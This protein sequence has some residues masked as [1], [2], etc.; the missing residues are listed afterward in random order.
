MSTRSPP[1]SSS[2]S[3]YGA[4]ISYQKPSKKSSFLS[5]RKEK[6]TTEPL[7]SPTPSDNSFGYASS[8][9]ATSY[10]LEQELPSRP[11]ISHPLDLKSHRT[12]SGSKS[13]GSSKDV[14]GQGSR[15]S[16]KGRQAKTAPFEDE[17]IEFPADPSE[18]I[19]WPVS[20]DAESLKEYRR[21]ATS[22][23]S[24]KHS[25]EQQA[26]LGRLK[27][28]YRDSGS[29]T[30]SQFEPLPQTPVDDYTFSQRPFSI[31]VVVAAPIAGVETMD[32]LVDGMNGS[33][34]DDNPYPSSGGHASRSQFKKMG[35]H[36]LYH[37]PLPKPP[38]G[39]TLGVPRKSKKQSESESEDDS[40]RASS[41]HSWKD[42]ERNSRPRPSRTPSNMTVTRYPTFNMPVVPSSSSRT[43]LASTVDA[44]SIPDSNDDLHSIRSRP[45]SVLRTSPP[46]CLP[47]TAPTIDEIIKTHAPQV[48]RAT[49]SRRTSYTF[50]AGH[51]TA[52]DVHPVTSPKPISHESDTDLVSRSSV[53]TIAEEIRL[54]IRNQKTSAVTT[55]SEVMQQRLY[56][57]APR[58]RSSGTDYAISEDRRNS[59][60]FD[61]STI[62]EQVGL[63]P[64]DISQLTKAPIHSASQNIARYLRSSR[65]TTM[66]RLTRSP[67]ASREFPL[68]VSLSDL[69]SPTGTPLVVF[70]GL[71]CVR[72]IMGLYDEMAELL[73]I[74]LIT[75]DRWGLGRT[76]SPRLKGAKGIPEWAT[77]VEEV[78]DALNIDQCSIMAHSAGAPYALAFASRFPERIRGDLCLLAPWVGGGENS[79]YKWLKY[80]PNGILKT[81]QAAEWK[82]QA[83]ML[84]KPPTIAYQGIGFDVKATSPPPTSYDASLPLSPTF[85][86]GDGH[87]GDDAET[88]SRS[89]ESDYDD[90]RDFDGR[91]ESRSTLGRRSTCSHR[92]RTIS[93]SKGS[94]N[95]MRKPS[96]GF[97]G[98]LKTGGQQQPAPQSQSPQPE[99][100]QSGPGKRLKALRSMSSLKGRSST[101]PTHAKKS[102]TPPSSMPWL[103]QPEASEM[104]LGLDDLGWQSTMKAKSHTVS[105]GSKSVKSEALSSL[106]LSFDSPTPFPRASGRRSVS[107]G[108]SVTRASSRAGTIPPVPALPT[109]PIPMSP[110]LRSPGPA[111]P[112]PE[113]P[114]TPSNSYQAALGNALIAASHAESSKGTHSDLVQILNHDRQPWGFSYANYPHTVRVWYGDRDERIAE[115][116]VRWME[117]TMSRDKC[118]VK[119]VKGADHA[120]MFKSGVVVEVLEYISECWHPD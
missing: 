92:S 40:K 62:S 95:A 70:L 113:T 86:R 7:P 11:I 71:G 63:P 5:L 116:A 108:A 22:G 115:N 13:I 74:R 112:L 20:E 59:S 89:S 33:S 44:V 88:R 54:T 55:S 68:N 1:L 93:E 119:V 38:P 60:L 25:W 120:L 96:R 67:H 57:A 81:A 101:T 100:A 45:A 16:Q 47:S 34:E 97:L 18:H 6:R 42:K 94:R 78:L 61:S 43:S 39:V 117:N 46:V 79:S 91:F 36:P 85:G 32:A 10:A 48:A 69:G 82:V 110:R 99:R 56:T 114:T 83:W 64:M 3:P 26:Y 102:S 52:H 12:R 19:P 28:S 87:G 104:G 73:G 53:D 109:S 111:S 17:V 66:L 98:L 106:D 30:L 23:P 58:P 76:D 37:P 27:Y 51:S 15:G 14:K 24:K 21:R 118:Q 9:T 65:L 29:S 80:V 72:H 107:F 49:I 8:A 35:F 4:P 103:P 75:I 31:P 41:K 90:L 84:G 77:V 50:S 2:H 105:A